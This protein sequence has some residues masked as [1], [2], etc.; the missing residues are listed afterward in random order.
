MEH[1]HED[2]SSLELRWVA[3]LGSELLDSVDE[4]QCS[5]SWQKITLEFH[6]F[7]VNYVQNSVL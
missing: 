1:R 7:S 2:N 4:L 6:R 3:H 5:E